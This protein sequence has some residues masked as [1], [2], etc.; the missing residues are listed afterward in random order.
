MA[1]SLEQILEDALTLPD[2]SKL[3]LAERLV[4]VVSGRVPSEIDARQMAEVQRRMDEVQ[5]GQIDLIDGTTAL[6]DVR[7]ALEHGE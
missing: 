3:A 2:D 6:T 7:Q 1:T 5:A 4:Q